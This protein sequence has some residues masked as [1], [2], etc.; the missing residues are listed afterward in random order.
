MQ[1]QDLLLFQAAL[2]L[3]DPWRVVA[4]SLMP[5]PSGW[6]CG[7]VFRVGSTFCCPECDRSG[8]KARETEEKT[9]RHLDFFQ[10]QAYPHCAGAA[11]G[12][13]GAQGPVGGGAVGAGALGVHAAVRGVGDGDGQRDAGRDLGGSGRESDMRIWRVV[14]HY[15]DLAVE[16]QDL[17]G[18]ERVGIDES[19]L[20]S[21]WRCASPRSPSG[22]ARPRTSCCASSRG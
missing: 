17:A 5:G 22:V 13:P 6:I 18:V 19:S 14:H 16:A 4:S 8:L 15:V 2:G 11:G 10:H 12:M 7:L 1:A 20:A 9:W 3:S 21:A